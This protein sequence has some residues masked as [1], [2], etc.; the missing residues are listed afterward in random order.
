MEFSYGMGMVGA[1]GCRD[2]GDPLITSEGSSVSMT[3]FQVDN[4]D[5]LSYTSAANSKP[6]DVPG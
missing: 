2:T 5:V 1:Y 6:G 4:D 3:R